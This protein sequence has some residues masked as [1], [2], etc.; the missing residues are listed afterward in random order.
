ML[1]KIKDFKPSVE[2]GVRNFIPVNTLISAWAL[3]RLGSKTDARNF[4]GEQKKKFPG[5]SAIDWSMA[6][7]EQDRS[8]SMPEN[9]RDAN[10]RIIERLVDSGL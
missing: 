5:Y 7:F 4:I 3:E 6:V 1:R 8:F 9:S 10:V 2:N